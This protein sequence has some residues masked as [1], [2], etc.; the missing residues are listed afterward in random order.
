MIL[1]KS[2]VVSWLLISGSIDMTCDCFSYWLRPA[3][4][5]IIKSDRVRSRLSAID[6]R[7]SMEACDLKS[8]KLNGKLL[9]KVFEKI[10]IFVH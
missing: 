3:H 6:S 5:V 9:N 7:S 4:N 8:S 2:N 1:L 10:V